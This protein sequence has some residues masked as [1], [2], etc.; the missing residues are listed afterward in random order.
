MNPILNQSAEES[1][2][3]RIEVKPR[4]KFH[5]LL[6]KIGINS[7]IRVYSI[8]PLTMINVTRVSQVLLEIGGDMEGIILN[9]HNSIEKYGSLI[10]R[11]VAIGLHGKR[12]KLPKS[13]YRFVENN[14]SPVET[15][16][17]LSLVIKQ[18]NIGAFIS[19]IVYSKKG[20][21]NPNLLGSGR[22]TGHDTLTS[23]DDSTINK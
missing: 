8:P 4:T 5:R 2:V 15:L 1:I 14:L 9:P 21:L 6:Q 18:M 10:T 23:E 17:I 3:V 11:A 12:S 16:D 7:R 19:A 20:L 13:L 22:V